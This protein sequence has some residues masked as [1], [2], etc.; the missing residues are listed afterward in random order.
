MTGVGVGHDPLGQSEA[1]EVT[2][3]A[4]DVISRMRS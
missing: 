3:V 2:E 4:E 1:L